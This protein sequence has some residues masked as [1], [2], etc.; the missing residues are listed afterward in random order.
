M[1]SLGVETKLKCFLRKISGYFWVVELD[2]TL[3]E[4]E[5]KA[6]GCLFVFGLKRA[7]WVHVK[8]LLSNSSGNF[9]IIVKKS[10]KF[11]IKNQTTIFCLTNC[12]FA[13]KLIEENCSEKFAQFPQKERLLLKDRNPT[14]TILQLNGKNIK[15]HFKQNLYKKPFFSSSFLISSQKHF[16]RKSLKENLQQKKKILFIKWKKQFV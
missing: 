12:V 16:Q 4:F 15:I 7:L 8:W 9:K 3:I 13:I 6:A 14:P 11:A 2:L 10:W 5:Q 1:Q